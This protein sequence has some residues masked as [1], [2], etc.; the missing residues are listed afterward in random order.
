MC[1]TSCIT[2]TLCITILNAISAKDA[3]KIELFPLKSV[4]HVGDA[5]ELSCRVNGCP[6]NVVFMWNTVVDRYHGGALENN[7]TVSRLLF[8][9]ISTKHSNKIVC[10][11]TC[12][13]SK[14]QKT[15]VIQ[16]YSFPTDPVIPRIKHFKA[17]QEQVL[18]CTVH[19]IYPLHRFIIQWLRGD[20]TINTDECDYTSDN[21]N[22]QNYSS[23]F[24]YTPS[25]NDLGKS[26]SCKATLNISGLPSD[27]LSRT[28]TAEYGPGTMTVSRNNSLV[29]LEK[30]LEITCHADGN[31]QPRIL[32]WKIGKSNPIADGQKLV[33]NNA[34]LSQAGWYQCEA[35]NV[36]GSLKMPVHVIVQGPPNIP[37]IQ[38]KDGVDP[39]EGKNITILCSSDSAGPTTLKLSRKNQAAEAQNSSVVF[40]NIPDV[41]IED[42]GVYVCESKNDFGIKISMINITVK[43]QQHISVTPDLPTIIVPAVG[44]V[45]LLTVIALLMRYLR[46]AKRDSAN[47]SM[48]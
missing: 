6:V 17:N 44:S 13:G 48:N 19:N 39:I 25:V 10:T 38:L 27:R 45:S 23:A 32:W 42:A 31:P 20:D 7:D 46:K 16:V 5:L 41:K 34:S 9:N 30:H 36:V 18:N 11:A 12:E 33:I 14:L 21:E 29:H 2:F 1:G 22:V 40:L 47:L 26:I 24:S 8:S 4:L 43:E 28:T 37:K 15:S 3:F 35:R